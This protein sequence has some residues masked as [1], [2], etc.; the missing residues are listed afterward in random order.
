MSKSYDP[1][2]HSAEHLLNQAMV[3][4]FDCGRCFS[5]HINPKKSKCDYQFERALTPEEVEAVQED[6]NRAI[7]LDY[8][9][10]I[11]QMPREAAERAFDLARVPGKEDMT[12]FRV[13]RMGDYDAC[14]CIGEHVSSTGE[15]GGFRITGAGFEDNVLRIRFKLR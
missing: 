11:E 10:I 13:V 6:V 15:I 4:R 2:M 1:R 3:R 5:A 12:H 8:P 9:V 7:Q 14:P